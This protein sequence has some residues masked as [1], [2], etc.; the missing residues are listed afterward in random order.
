MRYVS[1]AGGP[2]A[3]GQRMIAPA[4]CPSVELLQLC[5]EAAEDARL[6]GELNKLLCADPAGRVRWVLAA[7][8]KHGAE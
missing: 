5:A 8:E 2:Y 3:T 4:D 6:L 7:W 1:L